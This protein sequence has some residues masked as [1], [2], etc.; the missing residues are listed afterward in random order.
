MNVYK[1]TL[2]FFADIGQS[3]KGVVIYEAI[4][5]FHPDGRTGS[6]DG[7]Y[8][9]LCCRHPGYVYGGGTGAVCCAYRASF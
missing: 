6:V 1:D 3:Y 5:I 8:G 4:I 2:A 7:Q 9:Q